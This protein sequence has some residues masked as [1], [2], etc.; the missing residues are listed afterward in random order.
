MF[1]KKT[2]YKSIGFSI[3]I[4]ALII[5]LLMAFS[6]SQ[7]VDM[8]EYVTIGF[9]EFGNS[10]SSG[11]IKKS[12]PKKKSIEKKEKKAVAVPIAENVDETNEVT[13]AKVKKKEEKKT[14]EKKVEKD[15]G[16]EDNT[17]GK[18]N[19][20]FE[21]DFGGNGKRKI[22]SYNIPAYPRGV[23][24]EINIKLKFTIMPDGSVS[25]IIL[26]QKADTRLEAAA[27]NSLRQ[28]RFEPLPEGKDSK[29]QTVAITFPF[30]L[31]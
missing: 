11:T 28:W 23:S 26:V 27:M 3:T 15:K 5:F 13:S 14:E 12:D 20:G 21:L 9:G 8:N 10:S 2:K 19:F 7:E 4:H 6:I 16:R 30:R 31:E 24:K 17:E 18:G 29:P 25:R 1:W 22:Y